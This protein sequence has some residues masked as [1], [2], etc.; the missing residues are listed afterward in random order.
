[1][2]SSRVRI[3]RNLRD[4]TFP[5]EAC[6]PER[7]AVQVAVRN[8]VRE[9]P[10]GNMVHC[11]QLD[12]LSPLER[13]V[14]EEKH[15]ISPLC[16]EQ[17]AHRLAILA[18]T[19]DFSLLVNEEDHLRIQAIRPGLRL[20]EAWEITNNLEMSLREKLDFAYSEPDGYSTTCSSNTGSG[21]RLSVM[22]F[23]PGLIL[24]KRIKP[25]VQDLVTSGYAVRGLYGE[26]SHSQ[27]YLLQISS[28]MAHREPAM[29]SIRKL[30]HL[31]ATIIAQEKRARLHLLTFGR[32]PLSRRLAR[33]CQR[34]ATAE[35][36]S[37]QTGMQMVALLR[38][39]VSLGLKLRRLG[40]FDGKP[41]NRGRN[42]GELD[43]LWTLIQPAHVLTA[44]I[45][46]EHDDE[47]RLR[48]LIIKRALGLG[49]VL[50]LH[51]S[52]NAHAK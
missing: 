9:M 12:T 3:A 51:D 34:L 15:L 30:E 39:G 43:Q 38:V 5:P 22:L 29:D 44:D 50:C 17:S 47:D 35:Q 45:P 36:I 11:I 49:G 46:I 27:G 19:G 41:E 13:R 2:L 18:H 32:T 7:Q 31:C 16:A 21:I 6:D 24:G 20:R 25:L 4:H 40:K 42:L 28:L 14:L 10:W 8:A 1:M 48:A 33:V 37:F 52:Q 23:L 26:G